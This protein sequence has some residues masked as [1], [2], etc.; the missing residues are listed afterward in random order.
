MHALR[1]ALVFLVAATAASAGPDTNEAAPSAQDASEAASATPDADDA[2]SAT[3]DND[4]QPQDAP[5]QEDAE[6]CGRRSFKAGIKAYRAK[7]YAEAMR[8]FRE[9]Q[10]HK[11]HPVVLFNLALAESEGG[12]PLEAL[13]HF[14]EVIADSRTPKKLLPKVRTER[15]SAAAKV[16]TLV[17]EATGSGVQAFVN[18]K[19]ITTSP[20]VAR[21]NPGK[22]E[23]RVL[24]DGRETINRQIDFKP[25]E[26][27]RLAVDRSR[28][29][30]V[31][32]DPPRADQRTA[33]PTPH[34]G[35]SPI[36]FYVGAGVTAVLGGATIWSGL[37]TQQAFDDYERDLPNLNQAEADQRVADGHSK[38]TRTNLLLG[39]TAVA[40]AGT[41]ALGLFVVD[42]G[43]TEATVALSPRGAWLS[44]RF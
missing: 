34:S 36:W 31:K 22:H 42:W 40:A 19:R 20:P 3:P 37:D 28:E 18:G 1:L 33:K 30:V 4:K 17:V 2:G 43:P 39:A 8:H 27:L 14:D 38:E 26:R 41:A 25:G 44:G 11:P 21:L 35:L 9:A 32:D 5:C 24:I 13:A 6:T 12:A 15:S 10:D 29:V 7:N 16:A 23:V